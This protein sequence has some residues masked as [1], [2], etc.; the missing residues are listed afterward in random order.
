[1]PKQ[2]LNVGNHQGEPLH[3]KEKYN[4]KKRPSFAVIINYHCPLFGDRVS[5]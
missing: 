4:N 1:M 3:K 5:T 2:C